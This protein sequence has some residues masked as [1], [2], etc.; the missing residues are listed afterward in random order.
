M[1]AI[2]CWW[3]LMLLETQGCDP[4]LQPNSPVWRQLL[5]HCGHFSECQPTIFSSMGQQM[6]E[7]QQ[8]RT[9]QKQQLAAQQQQIAELKEQL[10]ATRAQADVSQAAAAQAA[11]EAA[12]SRAAAASAAAEAGGLRGRL[13]ALEGQVQQLLQAMLHPGRCCAS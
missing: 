4:E 3:P 10:A 1:I 2:D 5:E 12:A 11:A 7:Q 8:Y 13:Q 9:Q 6:V